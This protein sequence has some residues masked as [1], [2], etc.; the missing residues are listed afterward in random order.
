M[1][2]ILAGGEGERLSILSQERAKPAK[3]FNRLLALRTE[4]ERLNLHL[5]PGTYLGAEEHHWSNVG[6]AGNDWRDVPPT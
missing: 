1:A 4:I 3:V 2:V 5:W 6:Q